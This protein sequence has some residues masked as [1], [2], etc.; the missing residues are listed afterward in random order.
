MHDEVGNIYQRGEG[1]M[2]V[3]ECAETGVQERQAGNGGG[4][5]GGGEG[6]RGGVGELAKHARSTPLHVCWAPSPHL[7]P[8]RV[9]C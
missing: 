5:E 3:G 9:A 7:Q 8:L 4:R 2:W 6:G 1:S